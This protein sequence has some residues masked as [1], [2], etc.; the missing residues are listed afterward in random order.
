MQY[1]AFMSHASEDKE[2]IAR[3]LTE[4]LEGLGLRVWF[5][6][7][8]I[9]IGDSIRQKIEEGLAQSRYGVV[10]LSKPVISKFWTNFELDGLIERVL[11]VWHGIGRDEIASQFPALAGIAALNTSE[12]DIAYIA[13]E[14]HRKI[15]GNDERNIVHAAQQPIQQDSGFAVFYVAPAYTEE[16]VG[17]KERAFNFGMIPHGWFSVVDGDEALEYRMTGNTLRIRLDY[18]G[19]WSGDE[20]DANSILSG[21]ELFALTMRPAGLR[22]MYFP[23]VINTSPPNS[24]FMQSNRSGWM[25]FEI[26]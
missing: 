20:I 23:S 17:E 12:H 2:T 19:Q 1:D 3:P 18:G 22:Q 7:Q 11:P 13:N 6:N 14:I 21:N 16:L 10:I 25:V 26:Q 15:R 4:E 8:E 24:V 5:D 9:L